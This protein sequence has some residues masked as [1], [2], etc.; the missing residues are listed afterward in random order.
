MEKYM[1]APERRLLPNAA[2]KAS[3]RAIATS[4]VQACP[5]LLEAAREVALQLLID[6]GLPG[7]DPDRVYFH[8]FR[9]AQSSNLT[10]TGWEHLL[11]K[12]YESLTLTQLV[13]QRF[14][15]T[16]QDN[17]D[18][19][20]LY[21]GFYADGPQADNFNQDNEIRLLGSDV[22]QAFWNIDFSSRYTQRL[23][24]YWQNAIFSA[25]QYRRCNRATLTVQTFNA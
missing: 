15:A 3:L 21:C 11:E 19:L 16:D 9:A 7:L 6:K 20:G 8:R 25:W 14:R 22:L 5:S 24:T 4:L 23:T 17:A 2:D 18:L 1:N 13:I 10:F 12:P